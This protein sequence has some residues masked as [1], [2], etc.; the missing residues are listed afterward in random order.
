M[1]CTGVAEDSERG[2]VLLADDEVYIHI[3]IAGI[4]EHP[5]TLIVVSLKDLAI[6]RKSG[7]EPK[8]RRL[9]SDF[10]VRLSQ[11]SKLHPHGD[12]SSAPGFMV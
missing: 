6:T 2:R 7:Q 3:V 10:V 1:W 8:L 12:I 5:R 11:T 9:H 4:P